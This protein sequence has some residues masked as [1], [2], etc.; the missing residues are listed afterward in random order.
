MLIVICVIIIS[1]IIVIS[2]II[3]IVIIIIIIIIIID[4]LLITKER[5]SSHF[6]LKDQVT[7]SSFLSIPLIY[8]IPLC[9]IL[10]V[11][12]QNGRRFLSYF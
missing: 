8:N 12:A 11:G 6:K 5:S 4:L 1:I 10:E 9:T 7:P 2:I 3:I